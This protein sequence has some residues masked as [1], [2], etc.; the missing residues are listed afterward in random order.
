V[1]S[2]HCPSS[3]ATFS[4]VLLSL[5]R[6]AGQVFSWK[7]QIFIKSRISRSLSPREWN[8]KRT[9]FILFEVQSCF[10][11]SV[12]YCGSL[13]P[14]NF[15]V[16]GCSISFISSCLPLRINFFPRFINWDYVVPVVSKGK[17]SDGQNVFSVAHIYFHAGFTCVAWIFRDFLKQQMAI[18]YVVPNWGSI[19]TL[20]LCY[21][22]LI[23][24]PC[25]LPMLN[26][27]GVYMGGQVT[28]LFVWQ[29]VIDDFDG[30]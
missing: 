23:H 30:R 25:G 19:V 21:C 13:S 15:V 18:V 20:L 3:P 8:I 2:R 27:F 10:V 17:H 5:S 12:A 11:G 26:F 24:L 6:S 4:K 7:F 22:N 16:V 14:A 9:W 28:S 29:F 1:F